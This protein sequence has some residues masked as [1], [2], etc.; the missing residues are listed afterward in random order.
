MFGPVCFSPSV[1]FVLSSSWAVT[2]AKI[3]KVILLPPEVP[4]ISSIKE[5][6]EQNCD[7]IC[8]YLSSISQVW[9]PQA[10]LL[11]QAGRLHFLEMLL[12]CEG[13]ATEAPPFNVV[14]A[15]GASPEKNCKTNGAGMR[16]NIGGADTKASGHIT[17]ALNRYLSCGSHRCTHESW[18]PPGAR[19][20]V[21][22]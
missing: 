15:P 7:T 19:T 20:D 10:H 2:W 6:H 22:N 18:Q 5:P 17:M 14:T 1:F 13:Q 3:K 21:V 8:T 4:V 16:I 12:D 11:P 9:W